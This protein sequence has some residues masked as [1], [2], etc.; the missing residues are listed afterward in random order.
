MNK[1]T[2]AISTV[3]ILLLISKPFAFLREMIVAAYYGATY[4]TDAYNM[5]MVIIGLSTSIISAGVATVI[6]PMYNHKRVQQ[7]KEIAD[8]FANNILWI[9]SLF[10]FFLAMIGIAFA[11]IL[12]K[13]FA[14][15]FSGEV[16]TLTINIIRIIFI[17]TIATNISNYMASIAKIYDKFAIT[18][19]TVYPS[20]ILTII[21]TIFFANTIGVYAL[22]IS[23]VLFVLLQASMYIFSVRKVFRFKAIFK[24]NNGDLYDVVKLSLPLYIQV[25]F[26]EINM[27]IDKILASGL[28]EGSI[29]AMNYAIRL[30][31]LPYGTVT[32]S[33]ITV[34]FP[35][36]SQ[37]AAKSDFSRMKAVTIKSVSLLITILLPIILISVYYSAEI[38]KIIYERGSFAPETTA[39]TASIFMFIVPSLIF[40]GGAIL[41]NNSFY[42]MKDTK[43]P[44][45]AAI[46]T[47]ACNIIF[48]LILVRYMQAAGLALATSIA[49]LVQF[50]ILF[51]QFRRKLGAFGGLVF[52]KNTV[53]CVV[54]AAIMLPVLLL[55][56]LLRDRLP[57]FV[58]FAA[59][60]AI[61]LCIY[62]FLLYLLKVN[63]FMEALHRLQNFFRNR[64]KKKNI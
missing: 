6:I 55:C 13:I 35:L 54:A 26:G 21:L 37:Y 51:I 39:L 45:F 29:S 59:G 2:R 8:S 32:V 47:V 24:L 17:F 44:Q 48:N 3:S 33:I 12:V 46:I 11:P 5:A 38:T 64:L 23:Y 36:I 7:S 20:T 16:A 22:V 43:T 9:T 49:S 1:T 31:E 4:Q 18:V 63:L 28:P 40:H 19:I 57:L 53:K 61:S 60:A 27:I 34:M 62:A 41:L 30:R 10:Y 58:F 14:P 56:E 25:G 52:L 50:V 42:S 15:S